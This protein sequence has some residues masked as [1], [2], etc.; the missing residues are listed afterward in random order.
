MSMDV[1][2]LIQAIISMVVITLPMDPVK[3]MFFNEAIENPPR[4]RIW[5]A[6]RVALYVAI[7]LGGAAL[8]GQRLLDILGVNLDAFAV[9][10]GVIIALMG[11]EMLYGG[12]GSK[13]QGEDKRQAG[14]EE[15]DALL[16]PLTLPLVAGPGAMTT[17]IAIATSREGDGVTAALIGVGVVVLIAFISYAFLG[18]LFTRI[19]PATMAIVTRIGGLLLAT[20]GVQMML[21]GLDRF[22][23]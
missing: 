9:V 8:V 4:N 17:T 14:P 20:I 18:G 10:G 2:F 12:G 15:G 11:F 7:I 21:G 13:T 5:A 22:F 3:V 1:N 16:I 19:K 6:G 23:G